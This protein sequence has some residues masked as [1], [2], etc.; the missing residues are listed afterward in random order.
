[1]RTVLLFVLLST[2]SIGYGQGNSK[3][4]TI[5]FVQVLND[6][7]EEALFYYQ[8]NWKVLRDKALEKNYIHSYQLLETPI[9]PNEP[10]QLMLITTYMNHQEYNRG[11]ERFDEL[12]AEKGPLR[13][14]NHKKPGEFRKV[15]FNK[16]AKQLY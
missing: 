1:M 12:I 2:I 16:M 7:K 6:N 14:M 9:S 5:D 10:F 13:L 3:I 8:N 4:S 15:L 11:E